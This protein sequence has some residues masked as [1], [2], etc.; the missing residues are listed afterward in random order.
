MTPKTDEELLA[1]LGVEGGEVKPA[2]D[3]KQER[4]IAGFED[5]QRFVEEK[6]ESLAMVKIAIYSSVS[7]H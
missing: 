3:A 6:G 2:L 1:E 4:I 5:I 7:M